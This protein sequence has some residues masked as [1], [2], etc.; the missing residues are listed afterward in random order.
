MIGI[1]SFKIKYNNVFGYFI[2]M[3]VIYVDKMMVVLLN[4][5]FIY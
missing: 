4:E 3:I 1:V 2:E 5:I